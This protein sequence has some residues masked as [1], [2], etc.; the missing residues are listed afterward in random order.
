MAARAEWTSSS[1]P[2]R[3]AAAAAA[4]PPT[5]RRSP[6]ARGRRP[7]CGRPRRA[8]RRLQLPR[9]P[10]PQIPR[11]RPGTLR[12]R[13]LCQLVGR[14]HGRSAAAP[15]ATR[16]RWRNAPGFSLANMEP[17]GASIDAAHLVARSHRRA[18]A[19]SDGIVLQRSRPSEAEVAEARADVFA[20]ARLL[21]VGPRRVWP[22]EGTPADRDVRRSRR[23]SPASAEGQ[24]RQVKLGLA[25]T[26]APWSSSCPVEV[27]A[28]LAL[29]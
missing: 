4:A 20:P 17:A 29:N 5:R 23:A 26:A 14:Q 22:R 7:P 8:A 21:H 1:P 19:S 2:H 12:V 24:L 10:P 27:F 25:P 9:R 3:S 18:A 11:H 6:R 13:R 15:S 16:R 28:P